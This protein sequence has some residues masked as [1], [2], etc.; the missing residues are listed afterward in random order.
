MTV[1]V[2][3]RIKSYFVCFSSGHSSFDILIT[4]ILN[5]QLTAKKI[6]SKTKANSFVDAT[7]AFAEKVSK[8]SAVLQAFKALDDVRLSF[9][10]EHGI[11]REKILL[12][13]PF[14]DKLTQITVK[15]YKSRWKKDP[16]RRE[17]RELGRA[18]RTKIQSK[19]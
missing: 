1:I 7:V 19:H 12:L 9:N 2:E 4:V 14:E 5:K 10:R 8:N 16:T 17:R 3:L 11:H 6:I 18:S 15:K 13:K